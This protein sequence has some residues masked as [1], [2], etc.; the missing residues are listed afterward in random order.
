MAEN[1]KR[2]DALLKTACSNENPNVLLVKLLGIH[3]ED[4]VKASTKYYTVDISNSADEEVINEPKL[5]NLMEE[6]IN[7]NPPTTLMITTTE[8]PIG[9]I[10]E[11]YPSIVNE[12]LATTTTSEELIS[13]P[14]CDAL[15]DFQ[16][17]KFCKKKK[18]EGYCSQDSLMFTLQCAYTCFCTVPCRS[19]MSFFDWQQHRSLRLLFFLLIAGFWEPSGWVLANANSNVYQA[20]F[21]GE[22]MNSWEKLAN[23]N[24]NDVPDIANVN[25]IVR[26]CVNFPHSTTF[27]IP[28]NCTKN[29]NLTAW[30][31]FLVDENGESLNRIFVESPITF[32]TSCAAYFP[33]FFKSV[34]IIFMDISDGLAKEDDV[35]NTECLLTFNNNNS[36]YAGHK[37]IF[38]YFP[39][40]G[41]VGLYGGN[42]SELIHEHRYFKGSLICGN[43]ADEWRLN[44]SEA[45][46]LNRIDAY[47]ILSVSNP[48]VPLPK[49]NSWNELLM[50]MTD[51]DRF[52][53]RND[54]DRSCMKSPNLEFSISEDYKSPCQWNRYFNGSLKSIQL[55]GR[56]KVAYNY[57]RFPSFL[58]SV[59]TITSTNSSVKDC[60]LTLELGSNI[61]K[62]LTIFDLFPNLKFVGH[63]FTRQLEGPA[64]C[65]SAIGNESLSYDEDRLRLNDVDQGIQLG[66]AD[67]L[68]VFCGYETIGNCLPDSVTYTLITASCL[69]LVLFTVCVA[70]FGLL[71][72]HRL[73][74][75]KRNSKDSKGDVAAKN[76]KDNSKMKK[77][78]E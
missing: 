50:L 17:A 74:K 27:N 30:E 40:L 32:N 49:V 10:T 2:I 14:P 48:C 8:T 22:F 46:R 59:E 24:P 69:F 39:N 3:C 35:K 12:T 36:E 67:R 16:S 58:M 63:E 45:E 60:V 9:T 78:T 19:T 26:S 20:C 53:S 64:I 25:K 4:I 43:M 77:A 28:A 41:H 18:E 65:G 51:L 55:D 11:E 70:T 21:P 72:I 66:K 56:M 33:E 38:N 34:R 52:Q 76:S 15:Q 23:N 31:K 37:N 47:R 57:T 6:K 71:Y 61:D 29:A 68:D 42:L 7:H 73:V 5:E 44:A 62:G 75:K 1:L 54:I 13:I